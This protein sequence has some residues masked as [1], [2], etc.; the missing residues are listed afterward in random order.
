MK[1]DLK[2]PLNIVLVNTKSEQFNKSDLLNQQRNSIN[3]I[4]YN[5]YFNNSC[6]ILN[7]QRKSTFENHNSSLAFN[8][9]LLNQ[10]I[11]YSTLNEKS[12]TLNERSSIFSNDSLKLGNTKKNSISS[13][14]NNN[15]KNRSNLSKDQAKNFARFSSLH[16]EY[17]PEEKLFDIEDVNSDSMSGNSSFEENLD[18]SGDLTKLMRR[19]EKINKNS[20]ISNFDALSQSD[21]SK[22][23]DVPNKKNNDLSTILNLK[24]NDTSFQVKENFQSQK[25]YR[26]QL[27]EYLK[28]NGF[29]ILYR[30]ILKKDI[31]TQELLILE[32]ED[33]CKFVEQENRQRVANLKKFINELD[34]AEDYEDLLKKID[35]DILK[36]N[37]LFK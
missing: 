11:S 8:A 19:D 32:D 20:I 27:L 26:N 15:S 31:S 18:S 33:I 22:F 14:P 17:N 35:D 23:K 1:I 13:T 36:G 16:F 21:F 34:D 10:N 24:D 3:S 2:I 25:K 9:I 30:K 4:D 5:P 7:L 6:T 28:I 37:K 29:L 12:T